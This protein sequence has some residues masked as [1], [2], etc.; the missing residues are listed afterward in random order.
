[1]EEPP[2][3]TFHYCLPNMSEEGGVRDLQV[4][5]PIY[6][7]IFNIGKDQLASMLKDKRAAQTPSKTSLN[8]KEGSGGANELSEESRGAIY[9]VLK[10]R[11]RVLSHYSN[12]LTSTSKVSVLAID[13]QL[14][15]VLTKYLPLCLQQYFLEGS[16]SYFDH[17][18]D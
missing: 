8:R 14:T 13:L 10:D 1:M 17:Y 6:Q 11:P 2:H 4:H 9:K 3:N 7:A 5:V 12:L 16:L 18:K 15:L